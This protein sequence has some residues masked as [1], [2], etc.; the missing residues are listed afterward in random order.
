MSRLAVVLPLVLLGCSAPP[1]V[2]PVAPVAGPPPAAST[3]CYAGVS[4]GMGQTARTIARRTV[5]PAARRIL[6]DVTREEAGP[7]GPQSFHVVFEVDGD[8]FTMTETG[9]AFTGSGTLAGEP[10]R[11]TSWTSTAKI[12]HTTIEVESDD[13][14]TPIGLKAAKQIRRDGKVIATTAEELQTFD[15][16]E[17]ATYEAALAVPVLDAAA[18]E[19]AC[20]NYATL[21]F[22]Q[23]ADGELAAL[24]EAARADARSRKTAELAD[25][26]APGV[27]DCASQCLA[28]NNA[29]QTACMGAATT[30]DALTACTPD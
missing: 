29:T 27:A 15:C 25:K 16:A 30:V 11:W 19:R 18:C 7:R 21:R 4:R 8:H 10:W 3:T 9:G 22:W 23:R 24:P 14:L 26:L 12:P 28:A 13:E 6:E 1:P 20:R 5:D 17:W 2:A